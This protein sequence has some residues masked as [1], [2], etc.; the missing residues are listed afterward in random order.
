VELD[1]V[2]GVDAAG[3]LAF[4][5]VREG[6]DHELLMRIDTAVNSIVGCTCSG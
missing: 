2:E 4:V 1:A 6:P 5:E 3:G